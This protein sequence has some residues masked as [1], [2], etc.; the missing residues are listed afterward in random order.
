MKRKL[1][2]LVSTQDNIVGHSVMVTTKS[3]ESLWGKIWNLNVVIPYSTVDEIICASKSFCAMT[4]F[5]IIM[6]L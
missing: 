2:T 3:E 5:H 6:I 4:E 1:K